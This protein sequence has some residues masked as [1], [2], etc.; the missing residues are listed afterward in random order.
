MIYKCLITILLYG[1][2]G[3][4]G[5]H[6]NAVHAQQTDL[7][8]RH[9]SFKDGLVQSPVTSMLQD[10][11]GFIWIGNWKGLTRYDGYEFRNFRY[12]NDRHKN[13]S[14][15]K[16]NAMLEDDEGRL[17]IATANGLNLYHPSTEQFEYFGSDSLKGGKNYISGIIQDNHGNI[18]VSTFGGVFMVDMVNRQ[19][20]DSPLF[21]GIA[22]T[23][24]LDRQQR[25][26]VGTMAGVRIY[27]LDNRKKTQLPD[28]LKQ[29]T[30]LN[31]TKILY[32]CQDHAQRFWFGTEEDGLL[33]YDP[34]RSEVVAYHERNSGLASNM[35]RDLLFD[36]ENRLWVGTRGGISILDLATRVFTSH[37]H[38]AHLPHT[39]Y[40]NSIWS[41]MKDRDNNIWVGT[42]SGAIS[43]MTPNNANFVH[44]GE[45][46][47]DINGFHHSIIHALVADGTQGLWVGTF[48]GGLH[49]LDRG[50][51]QITQ[52]SLPTKERGLASQH[53][54]SMGMDP[55]GKL[56]V[57]T[58]NG[59]FVC[60]PKTGKMEAYPLAFPDGKLSARL[61]NSILP[62]KEGVWAGANGDGLF[63]IPYSGGEVKHYMQM[64]GIEGT[65]TD[66]FVNS[67]L[68]DGDRGLWIGTQNGLNYY[69]FEAGKVTRAYYKNNS[70]V[71][72]SN[73]IQ[74]IFR[75]SKQR[76]WLGT[77]G[78][79]L[80]YFDE[81]KEQFYLLGNEL[82]LTDEAVHAILEDERNNLWV[83]TDN[84]LFQIRFDVFAVPFDT[85]NVSITH[86][87]S[88]HGLLGN[89]YMSNASYASPHNELFF[90]GINGL[91]S[92][93]PERL[94][95][96]K[97]APQ[98]VFTAFMIRNQPVE[99]SPDG[100]GP[101]KESITTTRHI[102]LA[103]NQNYISITYAGI[104]YLN[105]ENNEYAYKLEGL[106]LDYDW[107]Y[108]GKERVANY[109][110]LN[111]GQ[112]VFKVKAANSD[113]VWGEVPSE[114]R[115]TVLPPVWKT[116]WA[117][118]LYVI[119]FSAL[120]I[121]IL[122]YVKSKELLRRDLYH[123]HMK[124]EFFT[125]ISHEIRTPL[126]LISAP[127]EQLVKRGTRDPHADAQLALMNTNASRLKRLVNELLD[128]RKIE[129]GKMKLYYSPVDVEK[130]LASVYRSFSGICE[131]KEVSFEIQQDNSHAPVYADSDQIEKVFANLLDNA[132]KFVEK[133]GRVFV[134]ME[135]RKKEQEY[136]QDITIGD[137]G[138]G[139]S[140][141]EERQLFEP[142]WQSQGSNRPKQGTGIGLALSKKIV[143]LH[144]GNISMRLENGFTLFTVSLPEKYR[145]ISAEEILPEF[146]ADDVNIHLERMAP[147]RA[148]KPAKAHAEPAKKGR[149]VLIVEDNRDMNAFLRDIL[150]SQY[151]VVCSYDGEEG[152]QEVLH[153][154]PDLI[155]SDIMM[156][157]VD[158]L[159][160]CERIKND[161]RT[162]HIPVI[163]LTA[164]TTDKHQLS[165]L[166]SGADIYLTKPFSISMLEL[167]VRNMLVSKEAMRKKYSRQ[168]TFDSISVDMCSKEEK[169]MQKMFS[170]V[171]KHLEDPAFG[172][173]ELAST[174]GMSKSVLYT[175]MQAISNLSVANFIKNVRLQKAAVLLHEGKLS[176]SETAFSVGF[177][178]RKYFSKEFRKQFGKSPSAFVAETTT[179][180]A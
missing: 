19:L 36:E 74:T 122:K 104:N 103:H 63:F 128:F 110:N 6:V 75:D 32:I 152:W 24:L 13:I 178:D 98:V 49:Y 112:Y 158:G 137:N 130:L 119:V 111:P 42:F 70:K 126:T 23:L 115:I 150:S 124:L 143:E 165:G 65:L 144:H 57:G 99:V 64:T 40:D 132:F 101:L 149:T 88:Q 92:F 15:G 41:L 145:Q 68:D 53:I 177:N 3:A 27:D 120:T 170:I 160:F 164:R 162:D 167:H 58:L 168:L 56:W 5:V 118:T 169:F 39:V 131:E 71:L 108:V 35:V 97:K 180:E 30:L 136:W 163:L 156:P 179:V 159:A 60:E 47:S 133:G 52:Y 26:W 7:K 151:R 146:I 76:L 29:H 95:R 87:N 85:K 14:R 117:Y 141:A 100:T 50:T 20:E 38:E 154:M 66:N 96:N 78:G 84:G 83:S 80:Y 153:T 172:V 171:E 161:E 134:R 17:W 22:Y 176:I 166:E 37:Q 18:W 43:C 102:T 72:L 107:H 113:G 51:N 44:Y 45:S 174:I 59:L 79:G 157:K 82:G 25:L 28:V 73:D 9:L 48:G 81:Q 135:R 125:N 94:Y 93:H 147:T 77:E 90:G 4:F 114:I 175:K 91:T 116:W 46:G 129:N 138:C 139:I 31:R 33:H 61:I 121:T 55:S 21:E 62:Q 105:P 54:K 69:D 127:L 1:I 34:M 16:V 10:S 155:I 86:Y 12:D 142:F 8:F 109:T 89:M 106:E 2:C 173:P 67:L 140:V 11:K 148:A 123:E